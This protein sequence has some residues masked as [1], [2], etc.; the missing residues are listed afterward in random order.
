ML[1]H[2]ASDQTQSSLSEF[3]PGDVQPNA[4]DLRVNKIWRLDTTTRFT[5]SEQDKTHRQKWEL[6]P[7]SEDN[8][9]LTGGT[10]YEI[11]FSGIVEIGPDEAGFVISR[12][13]LNRNGLFITSGLYDSGYKGAMAAALHTIGGPATIQKGTR[14]AQFLLWKAE[15]LHKYNGS[16]GFTTDGLI[17]V[18]EA[19]YHG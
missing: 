15:A 13:T 10:S 14:I 8:F 3:Q 16:Y 7:D 9:W 12:S 1:V 2:I 11:A 5:I 6:I 4:V 19:H 17:K 18:E